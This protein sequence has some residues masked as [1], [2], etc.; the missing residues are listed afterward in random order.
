[1]PLP[2]AARR[3]LIHSRNIHCEG[4]LRDDGLWDIEGMLYDKKT[5]PLELPLRHCVA[6]GGATH[7]M[8]VRLSIDNNK[9]IRAVEVAMDAVAYGACPGAE[10]NYQ[11]LV[12][13]NIGP[14]FTKK[15]HQVV[16]NTQGCTH[17][18][19]LIQ[20]IARTAM[21]TMTRMVVPGDVAELNMVFGKD[22]RSGRP[23]LIDSCR[24]Y[25]A[26]GEVVRILYPEHH[27]SPS[28]EI[29]LS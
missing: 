1:M 15:M 24:A 20:C 2:E 4:F 14:G 17:V 10:P 19:W 21:Q 8:K 3:E 18:T 22:S 29:A 23:A 27:I 9:F 16:G 25:E 11:R 5:Y 28:P 13:L 26:G 7:D 6:A 12:G